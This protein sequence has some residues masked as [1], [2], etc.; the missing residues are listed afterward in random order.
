MVLRLPQSVN[1]ASAWSRGY[2]RANTENEQG[3]RATRERIPSLG[4][5]VGLLQTKKC[6]SPRPWG[7]QRAPAWS[8]GYQRSSAWWYGYH[9]PNHVPQH[10]RRA[11]KKSQHRAS[12]WSQGY[13]RPNTEP[14]HGRRATTDRTLSLTMV[15]GLP[16]FEH[17]SSTWS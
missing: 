13:H 3:R 5:V 15:V 11:I 1:C 6:A 2:H 4:M 9:R 17:G 16:Q 10:G 7:H 14:R 12:P 8:L